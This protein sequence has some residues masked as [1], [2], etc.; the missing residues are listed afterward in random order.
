MIG[1]VFHWRFAC[2]CVCIG[3]VFDYI[4]YQ[5]QEE[6]ESNNQQYVMRIMN[7][8]DYNYLQNDCEGQNKTTKLLNNSSIL[9]IYIHSTTR[10]KRCRVMV[11]MHWHHII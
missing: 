8:V 5:I 2:I 3:I 7:N 10:Y 11:D 9:I 6:K 4:S 1:I